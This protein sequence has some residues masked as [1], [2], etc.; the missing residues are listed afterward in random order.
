MVFIEKNKK[1]NF[2]ETEGTQ[3]LYR[4]YQYL[5]SNSKKE[6]EKINEDSYS[7]YIWKAYKDEKD[8]INFNLDNLEQRDVHDN[9]KEKK[10]NELQ[11]LIKELKAKLIKKENDCNR[12]NLNYAKLYKRT[13]K[14]EITYEKLL[15]ENE[16]LTLENKFGE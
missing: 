16:R 1:K 11:I 15:E 6:K 2:S 13:K 5:K 3:P 12:I 9:E 14:P 10:I 7:N 8:F 4:R